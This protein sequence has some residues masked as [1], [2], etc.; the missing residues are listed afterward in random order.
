LVAATLSTDRRGRPD[1]AEY[2][3]K[4]LILLVTGRVSAGSTNRLQDGRSAC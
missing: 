4:L 1:H 3:P 2:M